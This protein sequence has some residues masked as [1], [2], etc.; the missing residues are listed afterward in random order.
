VFR[1][2]DA[3][4]N[5]GM[6]Q[7]KWIKEVLSKKRSAIDENLASMK[8]IDG[9]IHYLRMRTKDLCKVKCE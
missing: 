9:T 8:T 6:A 7:E 2:N 3:V 1:K 4:Q 5:Y